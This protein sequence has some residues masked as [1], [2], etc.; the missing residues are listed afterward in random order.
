MLGGVIGAVLLSG[1]W[2]PA[3]TLSVGGVAL[4][5]EN[6]AREAILLLVIGLSW[7]VTPRSIR[8]RNAFTW[9]PVREVAKLFAGIFITIVPVIVILAAGADGALA[10]IIN[11]VERADGPND[12]AYFWVTGL[13]SSFLDNAPTYL[14]FFKAAGGNAEAL[15][16]SGAGTLAAIS[17]GAV[18]MGALTYLGNAPNLMIRAI[19]EEQ[20]VKMPNFIGYLGLAAAILLPVFLIMSVVFF[21]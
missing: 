9:E 16:T 3:V 4:P 2:H 21:M 11:L 8:A 19:A 10:P 6:L 13:L 7:W 15:T 18:F 5:L 12:F 1:L 14:I 17:A 20:G